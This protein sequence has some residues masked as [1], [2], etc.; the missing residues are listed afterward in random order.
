[1]LVIPPPYATTFKSW[2][3]KSINSVEIWPLM[4]KFNKIIFSKLWLINFKKR[5]S[6]LYFMWHRVLEKVYSFLWLGLQATKVIVKIEATKIGSESPY[7]E[8]CIL[9]SLNGQICKKK[10][11]GTIG[12][13]GTLWPPI[14][15]AL[16][17]QNDTLKRKEI[18]I[19]IQICRKR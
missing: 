1:M 15:G 18:A 6:T 7:L 8:Y 14:F 17:V 9:D 5:M 10:N 12:P 2:S 3:F 16:N 11:V 4:T 19:R 13:K